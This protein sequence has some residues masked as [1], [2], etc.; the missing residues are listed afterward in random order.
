MPFSF[1]KLT[2]DV[3]PY[4]D[5]PSGKSSPTEN[6]YRSLKLSSSNNTE[7]DL[8]GSVDLVDLPPDNDLKCAP[9]DK[10]ET[11]ANQLRLHIEDQRAPANNSNKVHP[12][13]VNPGDRLQHQTDDQST[14]ADNNNEV[15]PVR[16]PEEQL[17]RKRNDQWAPTNGILPQD[18]SRDSPPQGQDIERR[19]SFSSLPS[20]REEHLPVKRSSSASPGGQRKLQLGKG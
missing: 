2:E 8:K 16:L 7:Q 17:R 1:T 9:P 14:P 5:F 10:V 18:R 11:L 15:L 12:V 4:L 20:K 3:I 6:S 19:H 13:E